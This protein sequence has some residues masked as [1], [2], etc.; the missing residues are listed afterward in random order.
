MGPIEPQAGGVDHAVDQVKRRQAFIEK[1]PRVE[2]T[3]PRENRTPLWRARW[4]DGLAWVKAEA[5]ESRYLLDFLEKY[6]T[7]RKVGT[8]G[9]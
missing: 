8:E 3:G 6:F 5:T 4:L 1:H 9:R 2:I 7:Q